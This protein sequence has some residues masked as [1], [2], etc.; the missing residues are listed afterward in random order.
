MNE[1]GLS[2]PVSQMTTA[3]WALFKALYVDSLIYSSLTALWEA[4]EVLLLAHF[5]GEVTEA[6]RGKVTCPSSYSK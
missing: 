1:V 2:I 3:H 4:G 6:Q 5:T